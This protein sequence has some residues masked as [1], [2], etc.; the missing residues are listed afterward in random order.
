MSDGIV[1]S[2]TLYGKVIDE[3]NEWLNWYE[4][5]QHITKLLGYDAN[6]FSIEGEKMASGKVMNIKRCEKKLL[7]II[8]KSSS[9]QWLSVYSLP[10]NYESASFDYNVLLTR[11]SESVTL[12]AHKDDLK[13]IDED[14]LID[15]LKEHIK[16]KNGEIY[17]MERDECPLLYASKVNPLYFF[18]TLQVIKKI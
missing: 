16:I 5:A 12:M 4:K 10:L 14:E 2:V 6:Y 11:D 15:L 13:K 9:I 3:K 17:E 8:K 1:R 7:E 18:K